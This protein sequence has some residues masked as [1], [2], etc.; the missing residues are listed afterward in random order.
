MKELDTWTS[1]NKQLRTYVAKRID[2]AHVDDVVADIVLR[3]VEHQDK[4]EQANNPFA[5]LY[6]VAGNI[7]TDH[8][9][10]RGVERNAL[11]RY[12]ES[13]R[14]LDEPESSD[15][16][17]EL[18]QC[19]SPMIRLLPDEYRDALMLTDIKG[20]TQ[21]AAAKEL[22]L[23]VSG[24]KSRVQ[25]ARKKLKQKL[26]RCCEIEVNKNGAIANYKLRRDGDGCGGCG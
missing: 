15:S 18:S 24:M 16:Y 10:R 22:H 13:A 20:K 17:A 8:Y 14:E 11:Q 12:S 2:A 1:F 21:T 3:V 25:R 26:H 7:I 6:R 4:F 9:R 5:W 23:S 19:L